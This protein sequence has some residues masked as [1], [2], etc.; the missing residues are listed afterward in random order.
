MAMPAAAGLTREALP[1]LTAQAELHTLCS[2]LAAN[3]V[4]VHLGGLGT[5]DDLGGAGQGVRVI[6]YT[7]HR[8][9][10]AECQNSKHEC[11]ICTGPAAA[12]VLL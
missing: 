12:R 4:D 2:R 3:L 10:S 9:L 6:G 11:S 8:V 1:E 5:G 7:G